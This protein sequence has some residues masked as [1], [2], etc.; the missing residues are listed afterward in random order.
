LA[1]APSEDWDPRRW[2]IDDYLDEDRDIT[3]VERY[4]LREDEVRWLDAWN[5]FI[6]RMPVDQL[7][8]FPIWVGAFRL[9]PDASS[10]LPDWK[11]DFNRK[12][13]A[14]YREHRSWIDTWIKYWRVDKFPAS[15]QK[16]EWQA[17]GMQPDIWRLVIHLRPSGIRVKP[18][19]YL[20]ALVAITQTSIVAS[21]RRRITPREAARL[22]GFPDKFELH[23]VDAVAYKQLGN[24]VNVGVAE[25]VARTLLERGLT[26]Q[27]TQ[28]ALR[29]VS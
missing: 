27:V 25:L 17:R 7:P 10:A 4:W 15:R 13:S 12:N 6:R 9:R 16:F 5:D 26:R 2:R 20:P 18:P 28:E 1:R 22:Q 19:T 14:I 3:G 8:G 24:A 21:R 11:V 23:P 29:L